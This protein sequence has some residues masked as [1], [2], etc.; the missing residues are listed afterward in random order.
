MLLHKILSQ[1]TAPFR[2][3]HVI[4]C[5]IQELKKATIPYFLD[6]IGN[7]VI[8]VSSRTEYLRLTQKQ[9]PEP[10]RIFIAHMDHPGFHGVQWKSNKELE[11]QWHGGS[12]TRHLEGAKVWIANQMGWF[13]SGEMNTIQLHP[14][15]KALSSA[16]VRLTEKVTPQFSKSSILPDSLFGGFRFRSP[17]WTEGDLIYTKAADDLVGV[18]AILSVAL[19]H[20]A[21]RKRKYPFPFLG[22]LT[23][24][25][26]VGFIGAM[27]HFE[28][29]WLKKSKRLLLCISI[30][31]SRTLAGAEIGKGVVVRLGD[32]FTVF[33]PG[34]L[35]VFS[36]IAESILPGQHQRRIM[37]GGTC[38]ATAT[39]I[40]GLPSIGI[41]VPLGNYHNQSLEGGPDSTAALGPAP[42]FVHSQDLIGLIQLCHA[43]LKPQLPW[44]N[45]WK[46][47]VK[48]LKKNLLYYRPF[49]RSGI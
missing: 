40:Y 23:R 27:S 49:L 14:S 21:S 28:L 44:T 29:G 38:E 42:E 41:S 6:P 22:L 8:G 35:R 47:K 7:L 34:A 1:P 11:V 20:Y 3:Q 13:G 31:T 4:A 26:E 10:L 46:N 33:D 43:L 18:F 45:P 32:K 19:D 5:V 9:T 36:D 39:T 17:V 15:G 30:E 24:A 16:R 2:E 37:D 12:P 25:E 48:E